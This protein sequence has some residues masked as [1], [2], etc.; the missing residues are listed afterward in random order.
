MKLDV[1]L[2]EKYS[3]EQQIREKIRELFSFRKLTDL[4]GEAGLD[5][6]LLLT[7]SLEALQLSIYRLDAYLES[8]WELDPQEITNL[9]EGIYGCLRE[10]HFTPKQ[11]NRMV[12]EIRRY[13]RIERKCRKDQWPTSVPFTKFYTTKSCDVRL[14]RHLIYKAAPSLA[15]MW[16]ERAW[17]YYDQ[18]TEVHDDIADL[19]EDLP[20]YNA[21]RFLVSWLREGQKK[22]GKQYRKRL[23][24]IVRKANTYFKKHPQASRHAEL[25]AWTLEGAEETLQLLSRTM[26]SHDPAACITSLLLTKMN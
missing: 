17:R 13:E 18:I 14:I 3:S 11:I 15:H 16:K 26:E 22:T 7:E 1:S 25:Y 5:K 8:T 24:R 23:E 4:L 19:F 6:S 10:M 12:G 9:W 20:T 2:K 21:N